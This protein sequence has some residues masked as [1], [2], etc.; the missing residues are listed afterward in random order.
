MDD[1][2]TSLTPL[3]GGHSGRT[4]LSDVAG[5]RAVVRVYPPGEPRG[6]VAPEIDAAVLHLV[7]GLLPVPAVVEV[8]RAE[9][10]QG[11]PGLLVTEWRPGERGDLVVTDLAAAGDVEGLSRL[12]ASLGHV[13]GTLAGMPM[14]RPGPFVG[15]DLALGEFPH[16]GLAEWVD[17][18]LGAWSEQDR[19]RLRGV[20]DDAQD[21]LDT[22][23]RACLVHSDLNP[24]N[25]LVDRRTLTVSAVL[26][27]EF[28]HAGH[29][30]TDV[31]NLLR[32]ERH[33]AY[34]EA[35]L[36]A[37]T[38]LRGGSPDDL[39]DGARAAD[40]WAL[41]ELASRPAANPVAERADA[42]LRAVARTGDLH[43]PPPTT[44][45]RQE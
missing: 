33:P 27:W 22:V 19:S 34:V 24:K 11:L 31:G 17:L 2:G 18:H 25:V 5:E 43:A 7:R 16:G 10:A 20:A 12:G 4:F 15:A 21:L 6:E 13:A 3:A 28:S 29:P 44:A 39:R 8:R 23:G 45:A 32:F 9:P 40:L 38:D 37:W 42:L 14:V 41:A 1:R 30:W 36:A 35:V 26:D